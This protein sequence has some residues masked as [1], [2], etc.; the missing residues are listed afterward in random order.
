MCFV[1]THSSTHDDYGS[2]APWIALYSTVLV[3]RP[4]ECLLA[5]QVILITLC[6][7]FIAFLFVLFYSIILPKQFF[8]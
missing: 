7:F 5:A 2:K 1:G 3:Q 8:F 4:R 6:A